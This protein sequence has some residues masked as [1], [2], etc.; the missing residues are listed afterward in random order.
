MHRRSLEEIG[1]GVEYGNTSLVDVMLVF[2]P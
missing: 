1:A 2:V